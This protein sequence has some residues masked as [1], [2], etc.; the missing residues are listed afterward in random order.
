MQIVSSFFRVSKRKLD[1]ETCSGD[2]AD[3]TVTPFY[4]GQQVSFQYCFYIVVHMH[5]AHF[6]CVDTGLMRT[7]K[8]C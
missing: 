7:G 2:F 4:T 1:F 6:K 3:K 8:L 5:L